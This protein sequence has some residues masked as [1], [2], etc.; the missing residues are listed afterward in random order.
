MIKQ[1]HFSVQCHYQRIF[2]AKKLIDQIEVQGHTCQLNV[3]NTDFYK[4]RHN[5]KDGVDK[6][7]GQRAVFR[8]TMGAF[9]DQDWVI[10]THDD[11]I[12]SPMNLYAIQRILTFAPQTRPLCLFHPTNKLYRTFPPDQ[13]VGVT[14]EDVW[15]PCTAFPKKIRHNFCAWYDAEVQGKVCTRAD[16]GLLKTFMCRHGLSFYVIVPSVVQH[17]LGMPSVCGNP[18]KV[19][20]NRRDAFD[21]D[22]DFDGS[23]INWEGEFLNPHKMSSRCTHYDLH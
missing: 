22:P 8:Q 18:P 11:M 20:K 17:D 21:Y 13:Y 7:A 16:D 9:E 2:A 12:I 23:G 3:D 5:T 10:Y 14:S 15:I 19:G 1:L 6:Y 4:N